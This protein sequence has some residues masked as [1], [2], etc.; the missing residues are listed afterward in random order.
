MYHGGGGPWG[1]GGMAVGMRRLTSALDTDEDT[2]LGK[3]YDSRVMGRVVKYLGGVK[4]T[5]ALAAAGTLVTSLV[6]LAMPYLVAVA[7]DNYIQTKNVNGLTIV[8]LLYVGAAVVMWVGQFTQTLNL[9]FTGQGIL[10]RMRTE[11]FSHL[12]NLSFNFFHHNKVGK[13]MSRVQNDVNQLQTLLTQDIITLTA[14]AVTLIVIAV[15]MLSMNAQLALLSLAV[16]PVL[17]IILVIW[18]RYARRTFIMVRQRIAVVN[19][20]LQEG[21]SGV[22]VTQSVSRE[23]VNFRQFDTANQAHLD[24]NVE[25]ARLQ[26]VMMP[27]VDILTNSAF[28]LVLVFGGFQVLAGTTTPGVLLAFLLYIQ[29]FFAP[30]QELTMLYTDLQRAMA[31]GARVFELLDVQPEIKDSP[32]AIELPKIKGEVKFNQVSFGYEPGVEV[33]HDINLSV[34]PGETVAIA[35]RTGAGKSSLT[36]LIARFYEVNSGEVLVDGYNVNQVTQKSLRRQI[37]IVP[38]DPFLF[39]GTVEDNI[40]HG[41]PEASHE[42]TIEAA[43]EAGADDF[44]TRLQHGYDTDVGERGGNLSA[45]QR[46]L[47]CLARAILTD[48]PVLILDEATSNVD[49]NTERIMQASLR[50]LSKG[51]T[52]IIIAHR[53]STVTHADR[54]IVM[55]HGR[56]IEAGTHQELMSKQG[57]YY[58]MFETLSVPGLEK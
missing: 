53:L 17:A 41:R 33:L 12:V 44:I 1:G 3:V 51:R 7:T 55:E 49:T 20:Q 14:D 32:Q 27:T 30:V 54:I 56:I 31:S 2:I 45:G 46:Q 47:I 5:L 18:Q 19:D 24:A 43:K 34:N 29:R 26:A 40:R 15:V 6:S 23:G 25:A 50:Q 10:L 16:V 9:S 38:Q 39:S 13:I 4:L 21:I 42:E 52:C 58:Q 37:G 8:A 35:G 57:L 11:L 22:R 48:P 36:N 28:A